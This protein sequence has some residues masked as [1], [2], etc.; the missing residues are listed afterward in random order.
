MVRAARFAWPRV[1]TD[2]RWNPDVLVDTRAGRRIVPQHIPQVQ[3]MDEGGRGFW[4]ALSEVKGFEKLFRWSVEAEVWSHD[5]E[6]AIDAV[7]STR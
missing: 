3:V 7:S 2:Y 5:M 6:G 1:S 4:E